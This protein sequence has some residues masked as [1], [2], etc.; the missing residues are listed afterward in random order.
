M[1]PPGVLAG[2]EWKEN[3]RRRGQ[4]HKPRSISY[5][6]D[7]ARFES[8]QRQGAMDL[9][10]A[11]DLPSP[12]AKEYSGALRQKRH[13]SK[14]FSDASSG[15]RQMVRRASTSMR[16]TF[17]HGASNHDP[18]KFQTSALERRRALTSTFPK[19]LFGDRWV[20][21]LRSSR[22]RHF[23]SESLPE[24][25]HLTARPAKTSYPTNPAPNA[26]VPGRG[27]EPPIL[28]GNPY[29]GQAARA[30]AAAQNEK[31]HV[32]TVQTPPLSRNDSFASRSSVKWGMP[33]VPTELPQDAESAVHL[34]GCSDEEGQNETWC[35]GRQ[36]STT[37]FLGIDQADSLNSDPVRRLPLDIAQMI[38]SDFDV[39]TL[40]S[41]YKVSKLWYSVAQT[42]AVWRNIFLRRY[43]YASSRI[44][45]M[46]NGGAGLGPSNH[47]GNDWREMYR[48]REQLNRHWKTRQVATVYF[49]GHTDSVYCLQFDE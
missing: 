5:V 38:F 22:S 34:V 40:A 32:A 17:S 42:N 31:L 19:T 4:Q 18:T 14:S 46:Q 37:Y 49:T 30:A 41:A 8:A 7:Q 25:D 11:L 28:S 10:E 26:V 15:I 35:I 16:T 13:A 20:S 12:S 47:S 29:Q 9:K 6:T 1:R 3:Q 27:T 33:R 44:A 39:G 24:V 48:I 36:I 45:A 23:M 21:R 2:D 43:R